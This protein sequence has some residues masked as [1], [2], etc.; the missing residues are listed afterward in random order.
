MP[1]IGEPYPQM[2]T[3]Q[4]LA[5][6]LNAIPEDSHIWIYCMICLNTGCR[7]DATKDLQPFQIDWQAG[8]IRLDPEDRQPTKKYRPVVPLTSYLNAILRDIKADCYVNWHGAKIASIKTTWR[9]IAR[10]AGLPTWFSP[11][12]LRHTV[13]SELRR[14]GGSS[15][16]GVRADRTQERRHQRDLRQV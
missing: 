10:K 15:M 11:K 5:S 2:A 9:K 4:Q 13:A 1:T 7:D 8:L 6:F 3:K 12:V 16:G 14:R